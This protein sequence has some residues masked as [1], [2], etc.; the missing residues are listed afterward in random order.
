[1]LWLP[2]RG[3]LIVP[4]SVQNVAQ[5]DDL[6]PANYLETWAFV[7]PARE[8]REEAQHDDEPLGKSH[9]KRPKAA[10]AAP[11]AEAPGK[12]LRP[13]A[14]APAAA[15]PASAGGP[16]VAAQVVDAAAWSGMCC[17]QLPEWHGGM[18][19]CTKPA[20]HSGEHDARAL[21][22][23]PASTLPKGGSAE[24]TFAVAERVRARFGASVSGAANTK[25][26]SGS[27]T[28]ANDDGNQAMAETLTSPGPYATV[29]PARGPAP[30]LSPTVGA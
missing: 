13:V 7:R 2:A 25:W 24:P 9:G 18:W 3:P 15:A 17:S 4:G 28:A 8:A 26:F 12:R 27:I 20:Y 19:G 5:V 29:S 22:L 21:A 6:L 1:M 30:L 10:P 11:A 14:S 23:R 16:S